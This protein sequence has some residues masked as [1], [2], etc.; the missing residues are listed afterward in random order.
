MSNR[1]NSNWNLIP[2]LRRENVQLLRVGR[3]VLGF[4]LITGHN[5]ASE[6]QR[7]EPVP[8]LSLPQYNIDIK[9]PQYGNFKFSVKSKKAGNSN[10]VDPRTK[11][12]TFPFP[13]K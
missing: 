1:T 8:E 2:R 4:N 6:Y 12:H 7:P 5:T 11:Y 9:I 3:Y 13:V 10:Q